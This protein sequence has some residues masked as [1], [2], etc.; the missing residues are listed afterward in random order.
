VLIDLA[1]FDI[2]GT[3]VQEY[4]AVYTA[5]R[6]AVNAAGADAGLAQIERWT[7]ADKHEAVAGLL[8]GTDP[9]GGDSAGGDPA[10]SADAG[11]HPRPDPDP[12]PA[13][14]EQVYADF[15]RR[16]TAAYRARPPSPLP[17]VPAALA[18]LRG[19]GVKVALTTGFDRAVTDEL[20]ASVGWGDAEAIVDAVVCAD[21]VPAGRPAPYMIYRAMERT[22]VHDVRRV[23]VV[24]D[25]A[26]DL[27]A[28]TNAGAGFVVGVLSGA[29]GVAALGAV[30]HTHLLDGVAQIPG[31]LL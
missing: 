29:G 9:A 3:T 18:E 13:T 21:E 14:V 7:G 2:A 16:L 28:G 6:E 8:A 26:L 22:G 15:V 25:T 19:R 10:G 11:D 30:R 5:L 12:D 23:L 17:G 1:V 24:G 20:L 27:L 31:L 4:G